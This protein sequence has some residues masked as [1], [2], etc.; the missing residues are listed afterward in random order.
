MFYGCTALKSAS[1]ANFNSTEILDMRSMFYNDE[2]LLEADLSNIYTG[3]CTNF[4]YLFRG[5]KAIKNVDLSSFDFS[6]WST[7]LT[8]RNNQA[9]YLVYL[10]ENLEKL[11][12]SAPGWDFT[13]A[14]LHYFLNKCYKIKE[15]KVGKDCTFATTTYHNYAWTD[16]A[17][18]VT[19]DDPFKIICTA[20][21]AQNLLRAA[22]AGVLRTRL[23]DGLLKFVSIND[24]TT[25]L[26]VFYDGVE[27]NDLSAATNATN[28]AK[29]T[30]TDPSL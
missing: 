16:V 15:W 9:G 7:T 25:F 24:E 29:I 30:V 27:T 19:T 18:Q 22:N 21:A 5:C 6:S 1:M 20:V 12:M 4:N 28:R 11:D 23:K 26:K 14:G 13:A 8:D 17:T 3:K 2:A 10:C